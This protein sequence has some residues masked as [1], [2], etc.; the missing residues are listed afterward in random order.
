MNLSTIG[1]TTL[2]NYNVADL[3]V[4][5]L[6][7][8]S[9]MATVSSA[10]HINTTFINAHDH[11][12]HVYACACF[13]GQHIQ[14]SQT[15]LRS[16]PSCSRPQPLSNQPWSQSWPPRRRKT[17]KHTSVCEI[18]KRQLNGKC[19]GGVRTSIQASSFTWHNTFSKTATNAENRGTWR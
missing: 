6:I 11:T 17:A 5:Q 9:I 12:R 14:P 2:N 16:L 3:S 18:N 10:T 19:C 7:S 4:S 13:H 8:S 1:Y 15:S